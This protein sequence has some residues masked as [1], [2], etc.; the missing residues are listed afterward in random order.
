MTRPV[1]LIPTFY[2]GGLFG[3]RADNKFGEIGLAFNARETM[4]RK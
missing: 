1:P 2:F 4:E 3:R